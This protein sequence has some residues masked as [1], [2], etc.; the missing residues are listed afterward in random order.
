MYAQLGVL[1]SGEPAARCV[2]EP[3]GRA[4]EDFSGNLETDL[5]RC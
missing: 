3:E 4:H 2:L 1:E 5:Y